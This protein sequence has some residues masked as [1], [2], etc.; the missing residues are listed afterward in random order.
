MNCRND[1]QSYVHFGQRLAKPIG[2][3]LLLPEMLLD[4]VES[5]KEGNDVVLVRLR[6]GG[7]TRL[8]DAIVNEV[9]LPDMCLFNVLAE[10][11]GVQV[12][13][14]VLLIKKA[15]KLVTELEQD[16]RCKKQNKGQ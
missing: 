3:L 5:F 6:R 13:A 2:T 14:A 12:D 11:L 9:V 7:E 10:S 15:V 16:A 1:L 4:A 8:V